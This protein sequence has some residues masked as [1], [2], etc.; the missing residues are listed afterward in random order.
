MKEQ[1]RKLVFGPSLLNV[2]KKQSFDNNK[3]S[4]AVISMF[5]L[6]FVTKSLEASLIFGLILL[7]LMLITSLLVNA[8]KG[9]VP[10][11][12]KIPVLMIT[13]VGLSIVTNLLL[14]AFIPN[15]VR[16]F[17]IYILMLGVSPL[18]Y[19]NA[20]Y[21]SEQSVKTGVLESV[22]QGLGVVIVLLITALFREVLGTGAIT[23]GN[24]L[25]F[26]KTVLNL[27]FS[28]YAISSFQQPYGALIIF[29]LILATYVF[30]KQLK[31]GEE[32]WWNYYQ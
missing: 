16:D 26:N 21:A 23:L 32:V 17:E 6:L 14:K 27:G 13:L 10:N 20:F 24:Y 31:A 18:L 12:I 2:L 19:L 22:G 29:G 7:I 11:S 9:L 15:L 1:Y 3:L 30:I 28:K 25:P 4:L 8:F 5:P